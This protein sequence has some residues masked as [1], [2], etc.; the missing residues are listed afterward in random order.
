METIVPI[1]LLILFCW[2]VCV[3]F[4]KNIRTSVPSQPGNN[5]QPNDRFDA[6]AALFLYHAMAENHE[7]Q[8]AETSEMDVE[9]R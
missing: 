1:V 3:E 9:L 7:S 5:V 8:E 6:G 2:K 4:R